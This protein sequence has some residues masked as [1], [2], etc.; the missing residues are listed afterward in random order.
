V[1]G[2]ML[3]KAMSSIM[4]CRSAEICSVIGLLALKRS[5]IKEVPSGA[6]KKVSRDRRVRARSSRTIARKPSTRC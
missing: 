2:D 1:F 6:S 3:R 5:Q 4:R